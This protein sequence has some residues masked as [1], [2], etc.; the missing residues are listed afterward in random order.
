M[1]DSQILVQ[2][3][4]KVWVYND[5]DFFFCYFSLTEIAVHTVVKNNLRDIKKSKWLMLRL[6]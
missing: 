6:L 5:S 2:S 3:S 1:Y 4:L